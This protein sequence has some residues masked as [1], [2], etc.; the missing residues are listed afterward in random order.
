M[1][2]FAKAT[3]NDETV[4]VR[5]IPDTWKNARGRPWHGPMGSAQLAS[6]PGATV[7]VGKESDF[8]VADGPPEG[9]EE[10]K[11]FDRFMNWFPQA[12]PPTAFAPG[13]RK[14]AWRAPWKQGRVLVPLQAVFP[15]DDTTYFITPFATVYARPVAVPAHDIINVEKHPE[16]PDGYYQHL[17]NCDAVRR[18]CLPALGPA[19]AHLVYSGL[20]RGGTPLAD[21]SGLAAIETICEKLADIRELAA[22]VK[23]NNDLDVSEYTFPPKPNWN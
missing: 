22:Y 9:W 18:A 14:V 23:P 17:S 12:P 5:L 6:H 1:Y 3:Y 20:L 19:G 7:D 8:V 15:K 16:V 21:C 4:Y 11:D 13:E 10:G 2:E